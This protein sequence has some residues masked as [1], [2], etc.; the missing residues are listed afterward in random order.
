M[1]GTLFSADFVKD[2][3]GNFRLLELNTDTGIAP[4]SLE[5]I[6]FVGFFNLLGSFNINQLDIIYKKN[7][8]ANFVTELEEYVTSNATFITTLNKH[9]EP[10]ISIFPTPIEDSDD[11]FILR[12][13]YDE[14]AIFDSTYCKDNENLY[15]IFSDNNDLNS[16]AEFCLKKNGVI[17]N[18]IRF[19]TNGDSIPD[20]AVKN[21]NNVHDS[22]KFYKVGGTN[23]INDN[24]T[25]FLNDIGDDKL[26]TNYY[27][28]LDS[29]YQKSYRSFNVVY[30]SNLDI[31]NLATVQV[32]SILDK[33]LSV[34][35]D[36]NIVINEIDEKHYYEFATNYPNPNR[37]S[38]YKGGVFEDE[39]ILD[40][41]GLPVLISETVVGNSYKSLIVSGSPN[42]DDAAIFSE[43]FHS[44]TI[45]PGTT[46]TTSVLVNKLNSNLQRKLINNITTEGLSSF[47]ANP[48][49]T[50]L[51]YNSVKNGFEYKLIF[52][53]EPGVDK[54][55]KLD[56]SLVEVIS[57]D[58]E[59]LNDTHKVY[60]LDMEDVD[61]FILHNSEININVVTHNACFPAGTSILLENGQ[62]KL[63]E[64]IKKD[65]IL[66]S[67]NI[68]TKEYEMGTVGDIESSIQN[69][70][71][72]IK[73]DNGEILKSTI[74]HTIYTTEGWKLAK[75][76]K[77]GDELLNKNEEIVKVI[78]LEKIS[79]ETLVY[80]ILN[81]KNTK[82]YFA[83]D[84]LVHNYSYYVIGCFIAG[85]Q[86]SMADSTEKNIEEVVIGDEV[87]S[88]NE[89]TNLNE[90]GVVGDLKVHNVDNVIDLI[91]DD[92]NIITTTDEHPFFVKNK[93]W[94]T[95]KNLSKNDVCLTTYNSDSVI[96]SVK[97]YEKECKVYNLL[98]VSKN[99][100][101]FA[102]KI[103]V[104]NK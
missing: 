76:L 82:N 48:L 29:Q 4:S 77:I 12:L 27:E 16:V 60:I 56:S 97:K 28:T 78:S 83:E 38:T 55:F 19:E 39:S 50:M 36:E 84:I 7:T 52:N 20:L 66:I 24:F 81:V 13:V 85:T 9:E 37:S 17:T 59:I 79:E 90:V 45:P 86:I 31:F 3:N 87:L 10:A 70:L 35:F 51:V 21:I 95:A 34:S 68:E 43:W 5:H 42:T 91:F 61:T 15:G 26:I 92:N 11:K 104:H 58:F 40:E 99:H 72:E 2:L 14:T 74:G 46:E 98:S 73:T 57:N 54:L 67:Y 80:H 53:I 6:D 64:N 94:V 18:N 25:N 23:S 71:I 41:F 102:N 75:N 100:N 8:H 103:L 44:G 32:S 69:S 93:G 49:Q 30:G 96:T 88:Y 1:K 63:I 62:Y 65:D 33:P 47:R 22:I 101:F 89:K